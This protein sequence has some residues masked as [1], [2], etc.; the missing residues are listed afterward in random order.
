MF[1]A[2]GHP[3]VHGQLAGRTEAPL[4]RGSEG[5]SRAF[6]NSGGFDAMGFYKSFWSGGS[7]L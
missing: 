7:M 2:E 1:V 5:S 3:G 4:S 6:K